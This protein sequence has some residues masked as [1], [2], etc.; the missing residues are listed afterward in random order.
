MEFLTSKEGLAIICLVAGY[1]FSS[2]VSWL[3]RTER[4]DT[5]KRLE[6]ENS[7]LKK[8]LEDNGTTDITTD[9]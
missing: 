5:I 1:L 8:I 3:G 7:R 2:C 4:N 9:C 6:A